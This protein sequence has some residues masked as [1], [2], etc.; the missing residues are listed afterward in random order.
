MRPDG[1]QPRQITD[2]PGESRQP[3]WSP[4]GATLAFSA[5]RGAGTFD[6]WLAEADGS[7]TRTI[8]RGGSFEQPFWSPSGK[9]I[10]VSASI[11]EPHRRIYVMNAD[12]SDLAPIRQPANV[13]NVHPAWSPDGRSIVFTSGTEADG[14][15]Y[16]V[17]L[18]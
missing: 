9:Q 4:N 15:L 10:A 16:I 13:E 8:T 11:E 18:I 5:N 12:G 17:D 7:N 6:V 14:T 1:T 3:W 2:Q